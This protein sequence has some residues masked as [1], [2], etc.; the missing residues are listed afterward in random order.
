ML[1]PLCPMF[2]LSSTPASG[3]WRTA[4][5]PKT[6]EALSLLRQR[7]PLCAEAFFL[8]LRRFFCIF[9]TDQVL[10]YRNWA[11]TTGWPPPLYLCTRRPVLGIRVVAYL[12]MLRWEP[13]IT[14]Y[15]PWLKYYENDSPR[16]CL[17]KFGG[18]L[19]QNYV[20]TPSIKAHDFA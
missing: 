12:L 2:C 17:R 10:Y 8:V 14:G 11:C 18:R 7:F 3:R 20:I 9:P 19:W 4:P 5:N 16:R 13:S 15:P 1:V 6:R